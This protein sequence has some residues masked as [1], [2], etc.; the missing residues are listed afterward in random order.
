[1]QSPSKLERF[2]VSKEELTKLGEEFNS[3]ALPLLKNLFNTSY[4]ILLHKKFTKKIIKQTFFEAIENC[5]VT[6]NEADWQSWIFRI[7]MRE[8]LDFYVQKENDNQTIFDFIDNAELDSKDVV[9][10]TN[11]NKIKSGIWRN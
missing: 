6:K 7:W 2:K 3:E 9:S 11:S 8:I 4:W 1:M 10:I 5:N